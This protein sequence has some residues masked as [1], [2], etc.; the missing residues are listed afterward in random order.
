VAPVVKAEEVLLAFMM[1]LEAVAQVDMQVQVVTDQYLLIR[2][3]QAPVAEQVEVA[4][5]TEAQVVE[6]PVVV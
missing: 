6:P 5:E 4:V 2:P 3:V 1:E